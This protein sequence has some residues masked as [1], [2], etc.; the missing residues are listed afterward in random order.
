M[1]VKVK[2]LVTLHSVV[3]VL[4]SSGMIEALPITRAASVN[5]NV[6]N[7]FSH[8]KPEEW[9]TCSAYNRAT[10]NKTKQNKQKEKFPKRANT[11]SNTWSLPQIE[12]PR[13]WGRRGWGREG[14]GVHV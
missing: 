7:S 1:K 14:G 10:K 5:Q 3:G 2:V 8:E 13:G 9:P 11:G 6:V 12:M 4:T